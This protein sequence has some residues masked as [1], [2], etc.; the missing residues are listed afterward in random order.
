MIKMILVD[1][2]RE[3]C[4]FKV[5][6]SSTMT[7]RV[8][9]D[10]LYVCRGKQEQQEQELKVQFSISEFTKNPTVRGTVPEV[11]PEDHALNI[12]D[13]TAHVLKEC[14]YQEPRQHIPDHYR[15]TTV[16]VGLLLVAHVLDDQQLKEHAIRD[17]LT[18]YEKRRAHAFAVALWQCMPDLD[19]RD[20][21]V[22]IMEESGGLLHYATIPSEVGF[23]SQCPFVRAHGQCR[24]T[25]YM[26]T[27]VMAARAAPTPEIQRLI[28]GN[29]E[30]RLIRIVQNAPVEPAMPPGSYAAA[31]AQIMAFVTEEDGTVF[32]LEQSNGSMQR[33]EVV[34]TAAGIISVSGTANIDDTRMASIDD[35]QAAL[36]DDNVLLAYSLSPEQ[37]I[38]YDAMPPGV[39]NMLM[40]A[41][42]AH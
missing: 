15:V 42:D 35:I 19:V 30:G 38:F 18:R 20:E 41:H 9:R 24:D 16:G 13:C 5:S 12:A 14:W 29:L 21:V 26:L 3:L 1:Q 6:R 7:S 22:R 25:T 4:S 11:S 32:L 37:T 36:L 28:L 10:L 34:Q 17:V 23:E 2:D 8:L 39:G 33:L 31:L 40:Q 27:A